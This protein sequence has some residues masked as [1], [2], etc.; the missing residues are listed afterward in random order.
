LAI[1]NGIEFHQ[2]QSKLHIELTTHHSMSHTLLGFTRPPSCNTMGNSF[3]PNQAPIYLRN[4][5]QTLL[6]MIFVTISPPK[7]LVVISSCCRMR[8]I[9]S[10]AQ[11]CTP[12]VAPVQHSAPTHVLK[13]NQNY[14]H[15][16]HGRRLC[17]HQD[18][19]ALM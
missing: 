11:P 5:Q 8:I 15:A 18:L 4:N 17:F 9:S 6:H 12:H 13:Q 14:C 2:F 10:Y 3:P 1:E 19:P 16:S 7:A